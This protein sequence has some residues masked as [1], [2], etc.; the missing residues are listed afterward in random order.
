MMLRRMSPK[1]AH[2]VI[3]LPCGIWS[4]PAPSGLW[5]AV[6]PPDLWVRRTG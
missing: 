2:R 3:P 6:R 5:Y 4:R 1:V